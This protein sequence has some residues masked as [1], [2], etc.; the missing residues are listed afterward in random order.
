MSYLSKALHLAIVKQQTRL[1]FI[2]GFIV[3]VGFMLLVFILIQ[4]L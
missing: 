1:A 2:R 4:E 3:G